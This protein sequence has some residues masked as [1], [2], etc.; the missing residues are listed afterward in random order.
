MNKKKRKTVIKTTTKIIIVLLLLICSQYILTGVYVGKEIIGGIEQKKALFSVS[1]NTEGVN[2]SST[3]DPNAGQYLRLSNTLT[4]NSIPYR[5]ESKVG[6]GKLRVNETDDNHTKI[7]IKIEGANYPFDYGIFAHANSEVYYDVAEYSEKYHTLTAYVGLNTTSKS[8]DGVKFWIYT[9]NKDTFIASGNENWELQKEVDTTPGTNAEFIKIDITGAKYLRLQAYQKSGNGNDHSVY[10]NPML[11]TDEYQEDENEFKN[12]EFYDQEIKKYANKDLSDPNYEL[13]VLQRKFISNLG[14]YALKRFI[15]ED[16]NNKATIEWLMNDLENLRYF[17]LGGTPNGGYFNA[18]KQLTRLLT[19]H[20]EDFNDTTEISEAGKALLDQKQLNWPKTK[21]NLYKRMAI[22]LSLTHSS[23]VSLWMQP[24][25][26]E[27]QS[28]AV[29]RYEQYKKMYNEGKFK[30]TD[31]VDITPW[32]ET[33]SI[34]EMR[35]VMHVMLDDEEVIWLNEYTQSKI[36]AEP[37]RAWS[38]LTPHPYMATLFIMQKKTKTILM[39][40]LKLET[41]NYG[42]ME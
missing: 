28:D 3:E 1:A 16:P 37:N 7:S 11:I 40:Y 38:Y 39:T 6:Y 25:A 35:Y 24:G 12:V 10:V 41:K 22:T 2:S 29:V 23:T 8:G 17:V 42:I 19:A 33:Y 30:A 9:S 36:D 5:S 13:L 21:G 26:K 15:S 18:L 4:E 27:N 34:E 14:D 20:K 31:S 32:F